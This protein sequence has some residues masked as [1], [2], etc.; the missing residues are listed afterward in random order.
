MNSVRATATQSPALCYRAQ[1]VVLFVT[2]ALFA[3]ELPT[4]DPLPQVGQLYVLA[5]LPANGDFAVDLLLPHVGQYA[6][7][8]FVVARW[9]GVD[10]FAF[11]V[12]QVAHEKESVRPL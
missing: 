1:V 9:G 2:T 3:A 4:A 10:V 6:E 5:L 11:C 7:E 8:E 12:P